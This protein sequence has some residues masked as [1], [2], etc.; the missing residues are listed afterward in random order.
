[1][2]LQ[3]AVDCFC[4]FAAD[5]GGRLCTKMMLNALH[6][7]WGIK[8]VNRAMDTPETRLMRDRMKDT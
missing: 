5:F 1:M 7:D 4:R 3:D 6:L 2:V 8:C